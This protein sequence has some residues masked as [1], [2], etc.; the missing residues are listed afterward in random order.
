MRETG[1]NAV[2]G[3]MVDDIFGG[4]WAEGIIDRDCVKGLGH[5]SKIYRR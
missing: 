4:I 5:A 3:C 2:E 1:N